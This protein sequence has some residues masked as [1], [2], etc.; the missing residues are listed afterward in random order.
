MKLSHFL[1]LLLLISAQYMIGQEK[2]DSLTE[3]L[4]TKII[5]TFN[6]FNVG[7][8]VDSYVTM[9][10]D[11]SQDT[12]NIVPFFGNS[13]MRNQIR[14]N[15]AALEMSYSSDIVRGKIQIQ[16]GDAP[17]LLSAPEK[18]FVK[19][20]RQAFV[21]FRIVKNLW[22]ETGYMF[23]PVGMESAWPVINYISTASL[24]GYF[25]VGAVLGAKISYRFSDKVDGGIMFGNPYSL[26]YDQTN[27]L[28]GIFF[29]NYS[30]VKSL[31]L[32]Y[33][34]I[35]GNQALKNA[36]ID[37]NLLYNQVIANWDLNPNIK[38]L[39]QFDFAFQ[40]N[41]KM[42]PDTNKIA[43]MCS[44]Y[45]LARYAFLKH[46]SVSG[47]Y[48]YFHD[49]DG[50][51]SG[52]YTYEGKTTGLSANGLGISLEYKPVKVAYIR[53]EYKYIKAN[54]GNNV[55]YSGHSDN[56]QAIVFT[57]GIRF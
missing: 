11:K 56:L 21:G 35:F 50:F 54:K 37:N 48:E 42:T 43:S 9:E 28:A 51:L 2:A 39:G 44:G 52:L 34:N 24:C 53:G 31:T 17:N 25:E 32:S 47:R 27:H 7:F 40:T 15:V 33:N 45:I 18:Q 26:A 8:Y 16:Y 55:Y 4:K 29:L 1:L 23:T 30:P 46:F 57:T 3:E 6:H 12:S 14:L 38:I 36:E 19:T 20:I 49:P 22:F 41:S 13:P 5:R 10:L